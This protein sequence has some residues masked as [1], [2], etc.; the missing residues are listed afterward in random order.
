MLIQGE[1]AIAGSTA[2]GISTAILFPVAQLLGVSG[3]GKP[4]CLAFFRAYF[5]ESREED[6]L[7]LVQQEKFP[8]KC[9]NL[10]YFLVQYLALGF[11]FMM[12]DS[13]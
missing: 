3:T 2:G 10:P 5:G 13:R 11:I 4:S 9:A 6:K 8:F 1:L 7:F 12:L